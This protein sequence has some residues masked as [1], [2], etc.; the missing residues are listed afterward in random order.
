MSDETYQSMEEFLTIGFKLNYK[1]FPVFTL[2]PIKEINPFICSDFI[3]ATAE[4][5]EK[6]NQDTDH[7]GKVF[8]LQETIRKMVGPNVMV[9]AETPARV[10]VD[11]LIT[12]IKSSKEK[13]TFYAQQTY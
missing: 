11:K 8:E 5:Y 12:I 7:F 6:V 13:I 4:F 2:N 9:L 10:G 1:K 3:M